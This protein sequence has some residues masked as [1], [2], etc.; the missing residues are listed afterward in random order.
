MTR[1]A[2][3]NRRIGNKIGKRTL[4]GRFQAEYDKRAP[5]FEILPL[6]IKPTR[7][8]ISSSEIRLL[9]IRVGSYDPNIQVGRVY[10]IL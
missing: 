8:N 3:L 9:V 5:A 7:L 2:I 10:S 4:R 1:I 6:S